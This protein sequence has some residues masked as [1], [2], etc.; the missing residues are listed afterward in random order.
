MGV[1]PS[2]LRMRWAVAAGAAFLLAGASPGSAAGV[3]VY[4]ETI[5]RSFERATP[6]GAEADVA[7]LYEYLRVDAGRTRRWGPSLHLYGWARSDLAD[8]RLFEENPDGEL[9]YAFLQ[10][11][12]PL[13]NVSARLGRQYVFD[14]VANESVDGVRLS[15]DLTGSLG[16][17]VYAGLPVAV[18]ER[19]GRGGDRILGGRLSL[20]RSSLYD[21]GVSYKYL[22]SDGDRDEEVLGIDLSARLPWGVSVQ[23]YST[24]NLVTDGWGEH[25][26]E[27][28][29]PAGPVRV[30][31]SAH[32]Y[33]YAH[34]FNRGDNS[35]Q[36]FRGLSGTG[37]ELWVLGARAVWWT[38]GGWELAATAR[39]YDSGARADDGT[40]YG[41]LA[42]WNPRGPLQVGGELAWMDGDLDKS[43]YLLGRAFGYVEFA[44]I[45][46]A[47]DLVLERY[48]GDISGEDTALTASLGAARRFWGESLEVRLSTDYR[49]NP[50]FDSDW[51]TMAVARYWLER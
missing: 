47:G 43:R 9:L 15:G 26:Y 49:S 45:H 19:A 16:A 32:R 4:S 37:N 8:S 7:P 1:V 13:Q 39:R 12:T 3:S 33:D 17:S 5:L 6:R 46:L 34:L 51:R 30:T 14:G 28:S 36:P 48:G 22:Q 40:Y 27:V 31:L 41:V 35:A 24:A 20:H 21:L 18:E 42:S 11:D 2:S 10:F 25:S 50:E 23:G 29:A 38:A 44:R